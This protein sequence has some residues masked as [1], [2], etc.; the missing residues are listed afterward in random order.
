MGDHSMIHLACF[1]ERIGY[2]LQREGFFSCPNLGRG[3]SVAKK[4]LNWRM[5]KRGVCNGLDLW[6]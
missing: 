5:I 4:R 1:W 3:K 6:Y 2:L